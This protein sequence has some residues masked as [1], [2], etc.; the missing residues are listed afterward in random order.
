MPTQYTPPSMPL[1][2]EEA[3]TRLVTSWNERRTMLAHQLQMMESGEM[4][5]GTNV[6]NATTKQDIARLRSW[7]AELD[8]LITEHS[9]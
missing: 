6:L 5:S 7:I 9:K 3:R 8:A 2:E 4:R 1:L